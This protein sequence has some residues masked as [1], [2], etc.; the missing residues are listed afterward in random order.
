MPETSPATVL[1]IEEDHQLRHLISKILDG[2]GYRVLEARTNTQAQR[3]LRTDPERVDLVVLDS[4]YAPGQIEAGT[5]V[6]LLTADP[7]ASPSARILQKPFKP[8]ALVEAVR[9]SLR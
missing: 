4:V 5:K 3:F 1:V 6:L 8:A 9:D 7:A 2:A